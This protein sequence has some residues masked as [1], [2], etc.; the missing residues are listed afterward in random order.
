MPPPEVEARLRAFDDE[1][2][3]IG[4]KLNAPVIVPWLVMLPI[5]LWAGVRE[6][7][8]LLT[9]LGLIALV[10]GVCAHLGTRPKPSR[11]LQNTGTVLTFIAYAALSSLLGPF[12]L[13]PALFSMYAVTMQTHPNAF[14]RRLIVVLT[15][16]AIAVTMSIE[17]VTGASYL[18]EGGAMT[19]LPRAINL[20]RT[21]TF[22]MVGLGTLGAI[23]FTTS[24]IARVRA[25]LGAAERALVLQA[26]RLER[27]VPTAPTAGDVRLAAPEAPRGG[28]R[29]PG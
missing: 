6:W 1:T 14:M 8:P 2:E 16:I 7:L 4:S 18:F 21:P 19:V 9:V 26:W 25:R 27:L 12:V 22:L 23:V 15:C 20:E 13:A 24:F 3:R 5:G 29:E 10:S 17:Y 11:A 28:Q